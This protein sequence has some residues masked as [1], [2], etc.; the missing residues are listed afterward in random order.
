MEIGNETNLNKINIMSIGQICLKTQVRI[1]V[2]VV[3]YP[4]PPF[5]AATCLYVC[6]SVRQYDCL[7]AGKVKLFFI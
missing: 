5:N 4:I 6:M 7:S 2:S 1:L 3:F